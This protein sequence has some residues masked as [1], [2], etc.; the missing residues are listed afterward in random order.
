M[1]ETSLNYPDN[2]AQPCTRPCNCEGGLRIWLRTTT[3]WCSVYVF[4]LVWYGVDLTL[5]LR[6]VYKYWNRLTLCVQRSPASR[7]NQYHGTINDDP[8]NNNKQILSISPKF[9]INGSDAVPT[10]KS[11]LNSN[12]QTF[13]PR[14]R[15]ILKQCVDYL[16]ERIPIMWYIIMLCKA[17]SSRMPNKSQ[18]VSDK[19]LIQ[20]T[21]NFLESAAQATILAYVILKKWNRVVIGDTVLR[22]ASVCVLCYSIVSYRQAIRKEQNLPQLKFGWKI[23]FWLLNLCQIGPR[24]V[25]L[26]V[27]AYKFPCWFGLGI[28]SHFCIM[29]ITLC[30]TAKYP[31]DIF[32]TQCDLYLDKES[33]VEYWNSN[34]IVCVWIC[35]GVKVISFI[36]GI[37]YLTHL[38]PVANDNDGNGTAANNEP[39]ISANDNDRDGAPLNNETLNII[40]ETSFISSAANNIDID[41]RLNTNEQSSYTLWLDYLG[42]SVPIIWYFKMLWKACPRSMPNKR[43]YVLNLVLIQTTENF[44]ENVPQSTISIYIILKTWNSVVFRTIL[45]RTISICAVCWSTV[46]YRQAILKKLEISHLTF[47]WKIWLWIFSLCQIGTR[48]ILLNIPKTSSQLSVV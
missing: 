18:Y 20:I 24:I 45:I 26:S 39:L 35:A 44:L 17:C 7:D 9:K 13:T 12:E 25:L 46:T 19:S 16:G 47:G 14:K 15:N 34:E 3:H 8:F 10:T 43:Q 38:P 36:V 22:I 41:D 2:V 21:E 5:D 40:E 37:V 28:S 31:Q 1:M 6:F 48:I 23:M 4:P 33:L 11:K 29:F 32:P 42:K 27:F 30:V